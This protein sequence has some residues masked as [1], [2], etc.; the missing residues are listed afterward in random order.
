MEI[1]ACRAEDRAAVDPSFRRRG[2]GAALVR[3][4]LGE[5]KARGCPKVNLQVLAENAEV[6]KFYQSL[7]FT[8]EDRISMGMKLYGIQT[9]LHAG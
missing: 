2:I 6:I 8:V 1:R 4:A 7:G 9:T 3:H 5:L